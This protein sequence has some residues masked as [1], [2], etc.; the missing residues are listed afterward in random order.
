MNHAHPNLRVVDPQ[1][2]D[3]WEEIVGLSR[4]M[5][6]AA[7]AGRWERVTEVARLRRSRVEA[8]FEE[9]VADHEAEWVSNGIRGVL[10]LDRE[11]LTLV[12]A[13][14]EQSSAAIV[15]FDRGRRARTAYGHCAGAPA[16]P[17]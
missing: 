8:F 9:P 3:R 13:G 12:Q 6:E 2:P 11:L 14:R 1:R 7:R 17:L 15:R 4:Q 5:L 16:A 10:E